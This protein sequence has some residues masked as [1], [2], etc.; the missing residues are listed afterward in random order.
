MKSSVWHV[1]LLIKIKL[2]LPPS[3]YFILKSYLEN[4]FFSVRYGSSIFSLKPINAGVPQGAV[5]APLLFNIFVPNQP[6][7]LT[8][9]AGDK[10]LLANN[11]NPT[12][13]SSFV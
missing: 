13:A 5:T 10:A 9:H 4:R 8:D 6:T 12:I 1:G 2:F 11:Q 3:Y 7:L